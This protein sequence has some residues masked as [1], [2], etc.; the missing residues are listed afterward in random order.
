M[1]FPHEGALSHS[2]PVFFGA[3]ELC[4]AV[5]LEWAGACFGQAAV[6]FPFPP[7]TLLP[8]SFPTQTVS[9]IEKAIASSPLGLNPQSE[10]A[11]ILVPVPRP[12]K[13]SLQAMKKVC[14]TEAENARVAI[15]HARKAAMDAVKKVSSED[16]RFRLNKE[17]QKLTDSYIARVDEIEKSKEKSIDDHST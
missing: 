6:S 10:G 17:V 4:A 3:A 13:E 12:S 7:R 11:D 8:R 5:W 15:R 9:A 2:L 14:R 1:E 16:E